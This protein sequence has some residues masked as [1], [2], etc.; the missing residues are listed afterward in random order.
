MADVVQATWGTLYG[1]W[2]KHGPAFWA[3]LFANQPALKAKFP[4]GL[5]SPGAA[6]NT[7]AKKFGE[8]VNSWVAAAGDRGKLE[9][10]MKSHCDWHKQ[11]GFNDMSLYQAALNELM[12]YAT[13]E[14]GLSAD[15]QAAWKAVCDILMDI[16]KKQIC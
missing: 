7:H 11:K 1:S 8:R 4:A 3:Q 15:Q 5:H 6:L 2:D 12:A 14:A 10:V 13:K 9:G 16:M